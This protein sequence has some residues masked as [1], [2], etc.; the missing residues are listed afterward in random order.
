MGECEFNSIDKFFYF[1]FIVSTQSRFAQV[2]EG[3]SPRGL[4]SISTVRLLPSD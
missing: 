4:L 3:R 1:G 2:N